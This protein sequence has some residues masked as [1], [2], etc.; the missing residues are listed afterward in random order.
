LIYNKSS[1]IKYPARAVRKQTY[2]RL[3]EKNNP[4]FFFQYSGNRI[5]AGYYP[6]FK[7]K[8]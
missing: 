8:K 2:A 5:K 7:G 4:D 1:I 3:E 6:V